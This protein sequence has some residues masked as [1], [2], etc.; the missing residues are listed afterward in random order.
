MSFIAHPSSGSLATALRQTRRSRHARPSR[1][2]T[3]RDRQNLDLSGPPF[4]SQPPVMRRVRH[5]PSSASSASARK[6]SSASSSPSF[7]TTARCWRATLRTD[8]DREMDAAALTPGSAAPS[9]R[10]S[11]TTDLFRGIVVHQPPL[12]HVSWPLGSVP[13]QIDRWADRQWCKVRR[14]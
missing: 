9:A 12:S 7:R 8:L 1:F 2:A 6:R 14:P 11:S 3:D 13:A 4:Y 5:S 10:K